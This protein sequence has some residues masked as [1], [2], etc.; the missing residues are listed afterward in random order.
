MDFQKKANLFLKKQPRDDPLEELFQR[1]NYKGE[2]H[3]PKESSMSD[4]DLTKDKAQ[5]TQ[6]KFSSIS[7]FI[8]DD[9][10]ANE[11]GKFNFQHDNLSDLFD[12]YDELVP[13]TDYSYTDPKMYQ[14][15]L[16]GKTTQD[17]VLSKLQEDAGTENELSRSKKFAREFVESKRNEAGAKISNFMKTKA[18]SDIIPVLKR[19]DEFYGASRK[20]LP[21]EEKL[22][23][24]RVET[25][26]RKG[27]E[28]REKIGQEMDVKRTSFKGLRDL[29]EKRKNEKAQAHHEK[30]EELSPGIHE[31]VE[32]GKRTKQIKVQKSKEAQ[33]TI[34]SALRGMHARKEVK[35]LKEAK[36]SK[37]PKAP[38]ESASSELVPVEADLSLPSGASAIVPGGKSTPEPK[39]K[40]AGDPVRIED[41]DSGKT[42]FTLEELR[43]PRL[44]TNST[45]G[46]KSRKG[47]IKETLKREYGELIDYKSITVHTT[48]KDIQEMI[49]VAE[50]TVSKSRGLLKS[51]GGAKETTPKRGGG[52]RK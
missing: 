15:D 36:A 1:G 16:E 2:F 32:K 4:S 34:A 46:D 31:Y 7:S 17:L 37:V 13:E 6:Q 49:E 20:E 18:S 41:I 50:E 11:Y 30:L 42:E 43:N 9:K 12:F 52:G 35:V 25:I 29:T 48:M 26:K 47:I 21:S 14:Y 22:K 27:G 39:T 45:V 24:I 44:F 23:Q 38:K 10:Y 33:T 19:E 3:I 40:K 8:N 28:R 5:F 51:G